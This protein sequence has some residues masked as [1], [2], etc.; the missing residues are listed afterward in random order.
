M[1][2]LNLIASLMTGVIKTFDKPPSVTCLYFSQL[3]K[4]KV[5][6]AGVGVVK[7]IY[8]ENISDGDI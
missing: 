4:K 6:V 2:E 3:T 7:Y 1:T 8:L 5:V